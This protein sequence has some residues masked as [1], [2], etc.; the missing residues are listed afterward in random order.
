MAEQARRPRTAPASTAGALSDP[1]NVRVHRL[2]GD[3]VV[4]EVHGAVDT[5]TA[6]AWE[7]QLGSAALSGPAEAPR[8]LLDLS[9]VT[10]LDHDGLDAVLRLQERWSTAAGTVELVAPSPAVVRLLHEADL[11]GASWMT[12]VDPGVD[13]PPA[14]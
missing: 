12:A 7:R 5:G 1:L 11:D 4:V 3:V 6:A 10:Y 8:L 2:P 13:H 14:P 9:G